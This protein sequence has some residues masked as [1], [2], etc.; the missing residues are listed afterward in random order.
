[1]QDFA[2]HAI[3]VWLCSDCSFC[4]E[5]QDMAAD[6]PTGGA[7]RD[8]V[9]EVLYGPQEAYSADD[10]HTLEQVRDGISR[11]DFELMVD[12]VAVRHELLEF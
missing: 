2:T 8:W 3:S 4:D 7:L 10:R 1:M 6:D 5:A 11:D 9:R 12:W